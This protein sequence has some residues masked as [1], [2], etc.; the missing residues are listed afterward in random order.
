MVA[1]SWFMI[2]FRLLHIVSGVIWVGGVFLVVAFI[3]P[4]ATA[5]GPAGG[6]FVQELLERRRL[7]TF[8][9]RAGMA[10]VGAGLVLYWHAWRA[11]G[12]LGAWVGSRYGAVLTVGAVAALAALALGAS[13]VKP[14]LERALALGAEL[15]AAGGSPPAERVAELEAVRSRAQ[16]ASR[17]VLGL[18]I[19]SVLAMATARYW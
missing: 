7:P 16:R 18:L 14:A 17:T 8:L 19:V 1:S 11:A 10:T 6:P 9:L 5:L 15:A 13:V 3:Q 4:S 12:S 2:V